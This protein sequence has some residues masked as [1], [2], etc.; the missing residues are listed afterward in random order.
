MTTPPFQSIRS[1]IEDKFSAYLASNMTGVSV[2]KGITNEV[3]TLPQV[4]I[5]AENSQAPSALGSHN[6]GNY[7]VSIKAYVYSSADDDTLDTHRNRVQ[8]LKNLMCDR[9]TV[10]ALWT[11]PSQGMLYDIWITNDEEGMSQRR[12]GN[13]VD[14]TCFAMLPPSP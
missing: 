4:I 13:A 1:I 9:A 14:F 8:T 5:Y 12:Y 10:Q 3:R 6:N 7:T 11:S 2:H